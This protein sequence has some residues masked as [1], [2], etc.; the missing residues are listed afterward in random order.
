MSKGPG[1]LEQALKFADTQ[2]QNFTKKY[3][4]QVYDIIEFPLM[5]LFLL[6]PLLITLLVLLL[7]VMVSQ[8]SSLKLPILLSLQ[9]DSWKFGY[10]NG[11]REEEIAELAMD[12]RPYGVLCAKALVSRG[13]KPTAESVADAIANN[14]AELVHLSS[15]IDLHTPLPSKDCATCDGTGVMKCLNAKT[16]F[17][18]GF[19]LMILW[20]LHGSRIMF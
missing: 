19:L 18:S 20:S 16:N 6:S 13:E 10:C 11:A 1:M 7:V 17:N 3:G 14:Q 8:N 5:F 4:Q 2:Y 9:L 12:G 15:A